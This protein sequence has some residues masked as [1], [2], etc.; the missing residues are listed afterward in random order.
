MKKV[1][2]MVHEL[3]L[4]LLTYA[5]AERQRQPSNQQPIPIKAPPMPFVG[6]V[7]DPEDDASIPTPALH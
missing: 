2:E 3:N 6:E 4:Q 5:E 1:F 7:T